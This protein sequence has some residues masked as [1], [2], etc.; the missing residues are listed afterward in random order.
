MYHGRFDGIRRTVCTWQVSQIQPD[1]LD[2]IPLVLFLFRII[3]GISRWKVKLDRRKMAL[4]P[5]TTNYPF[6]TTFYPFGYEWHNWVV[7]NIPNNNVAAGQTLY[8][9]LP[10][11]NPP[12]PHS[13]VF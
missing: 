4:M 5:N 9:H 8:N 10:I 3:T 6:G 11:L 2:Y 12:E 7:V 13:T 1:Q